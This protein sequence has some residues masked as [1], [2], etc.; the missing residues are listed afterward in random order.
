MFSIEATVKP[1]K[2]DDIRE[3][4]VDL[5]VG[6]MTVTEVLTQVPSRKLKTRFSDSDARSGDLVPHVHIKVVAPDWLV[7]SVIEAFCLHGCSGKFDNSILTVTRV[8]SVVR[9]RTGD[10]DDEGLST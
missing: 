4:L 9:I 10:R 1:F 3:A 8:A 5:G 6:G 7:E 2:L